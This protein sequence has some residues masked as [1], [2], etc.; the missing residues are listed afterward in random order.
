MSLLGGT[1]I[2]DKREP[3]YKGKNMPLESGKSK[4][5]IS[6]NIEEMQEAG[7]P[8]DQSVAA[9]LHNADKSKGHHK[10]NRHPGIRHHKEH[11]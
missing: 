9:A 8:H 6:H 4:K 3:I 7:H 1:E 11:R 5:V 2:A 10:T